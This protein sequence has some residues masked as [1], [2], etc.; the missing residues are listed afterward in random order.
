MGVL[1][2]QLTDVAENPLQ[3]FTHDFESIVTIKDQIEEL[4]QEMGEVLYEDREL[5]SEMTLEQEIQTKEYLKQA[6]GALKDVRRI[7]ESGYSK[8]TGEPSSTRIANGY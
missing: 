3:K 2:N 8:M 1:E 7:I 4:L 6:T 5:K